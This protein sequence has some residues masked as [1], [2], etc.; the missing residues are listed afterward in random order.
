MVEIYSNIN[1]V[2][3]VV[4]YYRCYGLSIVWYNRC[5]KYLW[6][7]VKFVVGLNLRDILYMVI[8]FLVFYGKG[9]NYVICIVDVLYYI[10]VR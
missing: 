7:I 3:W 9:S 10:V 1:I 8:L 6:V 4:Y 5:K 2:N